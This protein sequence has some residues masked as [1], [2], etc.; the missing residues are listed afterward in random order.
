MVV[1]A[2]YAYAFVLSVLFPSCTDAHKLPRQGSLLDPVLSNFTINSTTSISSTSSEYTTPTD[3]I[4]N[5]DHITSRSTRS[6]ETTTYLTSSLLLNKETPSE[7]IVG[8]SSLV[9]SDNGTSTLPI[10]QATSSSEFANAN[11]LVSSDGG[12]LSST[13]QNHTTSYLVSVNATS[14]PTLAQGTSV[15][16]SL[17]DTRSFQLTTKSSHSFDLPFTSNGECP[18]TYP[19]DLPQS[20]TTFSDACEEARSFGEHAG[21]SAMANTCLRSY[22]DLTMDWSVSDFFANPP[23][24]STTI[25]RTFW[26]GMRGATTEYISDGKTYYTAPITAQSYWA[27]TVTGKSPVLK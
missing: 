26:S 16:S 1:M 24:L 3:H 11:A 7:V 18:T 20:W 6:T 5:S 19:A 22:C 9:A 27:T 13:S 4:T 2:L 15:P 23:M 12:S 8:T 14:S 25:T 21:H 10:D 17:N